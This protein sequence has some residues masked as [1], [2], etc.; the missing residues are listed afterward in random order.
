MAGLTSEQVFV[1]HI[2]NLIC[3]LVLHY[4]QILIC[5]IIYFKPTINYST[6]YMILNIL[7]H[8]KWC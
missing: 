8:I 5:T 3:I 4:A 7:S 6:A 1:C 2:N